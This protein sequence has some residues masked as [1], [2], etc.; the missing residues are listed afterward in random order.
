MELTPHVAGMESFTVDYDIDYDPDGNYRFEGQIVAY[1]PA[2]H[3]LDAELVEVIAPS[4]V[5][6]A[7]RTNPICDRPKVLLRNSGSIPLTSCTITFG[8][9][10]NLQSHTWTGEL[11]FLEEEVVE[12]VTLDET[13]WSPAW[14]MFRTAKVS[15]AWPEETRRAPLP[16]SSAATRCS[17]TSC[18]G[19]MMR[20]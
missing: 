16:P 14:A 3:E 8:Q 4:G 13:M 10:G 5:K 7:S 12:L 17:T 2:N 11:G 9:P 19:F 18:V 6:I 20:V 1:G 15:A